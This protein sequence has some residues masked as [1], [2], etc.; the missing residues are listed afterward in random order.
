MPQSDK[1]PLPP[2][3]PDKQSKQ[4]EPTPKQAPPQAALKSQSETSNQTHILKKMP[5]KSFSPAKLAAPIITALV[6]VLTGTV[7]GYGLSRAFGSGPST[8]SQTTTQSG[9]S[10]D[11]KNFQVGDVIGNPD[12]KTFRDK[13]EG[14]LVTGGIEGEGSHHLLRPGGASQNVYLTS[15]VLD[16]DEL[17]DHQVRVWGETFAAQKAGWLMDVGRVEIVKLNADKPFSEED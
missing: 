1:K 12:E 14:V 10:I 8:R 3:T 9:G 5:A 6:I 15:S 17:V 2:P 11:S 16:L 7:T 4:A 13:A